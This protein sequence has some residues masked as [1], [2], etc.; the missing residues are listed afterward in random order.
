VRIREIDLARVG[1][2]WMKGRL[3]VDDLAMAISHSG[4]CFFNYELLDS[5]LHYGGGQEMRVGY[6]RIPGSRFGAYTLG[7]AHEFQPS[8]REFHLLMAGENVSFESQRVGTRVPRARLDPDGTATG[9]TILTGHVVAGREGT[10]HHGPGDTHVDLE[11]GRRT[12]LGA[13]RSPPG[14][15]EGRRVVSHGRTR[16]KGA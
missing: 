7:V 1:N 15:A 6:R 14:K 8:E 5:F 10:M 11:T 9:K 4:D 2:C 12:P 16:L 13:R 3:L